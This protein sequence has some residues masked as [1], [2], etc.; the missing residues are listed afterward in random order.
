MDRPNDLPLATVTLIFGVLS[1]PL[2]F[3]WHMVSLAVVLA[4][5]AIAFGLVG[6]WLQRRS[7]GRYTPSSIRRGALGLRAGTVGLACAVVMWWLWASN[8][9]F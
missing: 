5:L 2:A 4:V 1:V 3:L 7:P 9:L 8:M 6:R